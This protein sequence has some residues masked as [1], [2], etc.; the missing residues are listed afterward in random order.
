MKRARAWAIGAAT[1]A[2]EALSRFDA[3]GDV[4]NGAATRAHLGM[5]LADLGR[6]DEARVLL[7]GAAAD[8][9]SFGLPKNLAFTLWALG[10]T[11]LEQGDLPDALSAVA[12]ARHSAA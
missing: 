11:C 2:E 10:M 4:R 3:A 7:A 6:L 9:Q 12:R 5:L 8:G 1:L